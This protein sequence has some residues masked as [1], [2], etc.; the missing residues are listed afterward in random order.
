MVRFRMNNLYD[1]GA[2]YSEMIASCRRMLENRGG[3]QERQKPQATA[4]KDGSEVQRTA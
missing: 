2:L 1:V 3:M 4:T